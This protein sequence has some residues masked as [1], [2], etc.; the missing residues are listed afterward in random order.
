MSCAISRCS[1]F[2]P[3]MWAVMLSIMPPLIFPLLC[4]C[5][6]ERFT[7]KQVVMAKKMRVFMPQ[8]VHAAFQTE[9]Q[10]GYGDDRPAETPSDAIERPL[11]SHAWVGVRGARLAQRTV[12]GLDGRDGVARR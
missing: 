10:Y 8:V 3:V 2:M 6:A 1:C 5:C 9:R 12:S 4:A 11:V 7:A